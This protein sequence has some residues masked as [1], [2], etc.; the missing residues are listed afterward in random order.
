[1]TDEEKRIRGYLQVQ[2]AKLAPPALVERVR[3]A[4]DELRVAAVGV[5]AARFDARPAEGEWS[6]NEVMAHV[7]TAGA[8]FADGITRVLDGGPAGAPIADRIEG[9]AQRRTAEQWWE[10]LARDRAALF[11]RVLAADPEAHLDGTVEHGMFGLLNWRETLLFLR[12]HDLD[13]ARQ[14]EKIAAAV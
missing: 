11:E 5:P 12:I 9:G 14:L 1:M 2:A 3:A 8:R 7:V 4:M 10:L 6:A 13:H